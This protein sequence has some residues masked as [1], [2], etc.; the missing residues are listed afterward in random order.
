MTVRVERD[1]ATRLILQAST[2]IRA[3]VGLAEQDP[4]G[5]PQQ[6]RHLA[7]LLGE[8][9]RVGLPLG[10]ADHVL[11]E[12]LGHVE[13]G[14]DQVQRVPGRTAGPDRPD[15]PGHALSHRCCTRSMAKPRRWTSAA[16]P[17]TS[18]KWG[19]MCIVNL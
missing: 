1:R 10:R 3:L 14:A 13:G 8:V 4:V 18:P 12:Q 2:A 19:P 5:Q 15:L 11:D 16:T 17:T 6:H 7:D 9:G